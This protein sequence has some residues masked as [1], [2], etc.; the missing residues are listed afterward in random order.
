MNKGGSSGSRRGAVTSSI[1]RL[2]KHTSVSVQSCKREY[3][4]QIRVNGRGAGGRKT[5]T[6]IGTL[7]ALRLECGWL[8]D[9]GV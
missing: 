5:V 3:V 9:R 1:S 8:C 7:I 6:D 4:F 2:A